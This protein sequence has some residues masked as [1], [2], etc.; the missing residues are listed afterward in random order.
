MFSA[1]GKILVRNFTLINNLGTDKESRKDIWQL[2]EGMSIYENIFMSNMCG[3]AKVQDSYN[4]YSTLPIT[5]NTYLQIQLQDTLT[6]K[7]VGGVYKIY[8]VSNIEQKSPKLQTYIL[9]FASLPMFSSKNVRISQHVTGKVPEVIRD[10][11]QKISSKGIDITEDNST[12]N[13]F[14]PFMSA[15]SAINLL[16]ENAK[17]KA[18]IPDYCYWETFD[19]YNCKSL[20]DCLMRNPVHDFSTNNKLNYDPTT[21]FSYSDYIS[22]DELKVKYTFD[23][24]NTLYNGFDGST[25]Y[26]YDPIKGQATFDQVGDSTLARIIT[27][28]D[29]A[30]DYKSLSRRIQLLRNITNTYYY[31]S[32]PGLLSRSSGDIANVTIYNGNNLNIK[33]TTLSGK[34]LICGIVHVISNDEYTQHIT[35]GDYYLG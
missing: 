3:I 32:V 28:S 26:S 23:S 20:S 25:I 5:S 8:K 22:I 14:L 16:V 30:L 31:I 34:R 17:W 10:I 24:L 4:L 6:G 11:H 15:D 7:R 18:S 27:F 35:L 12:T 19:N 21:A 1:P 13:I 9:H 29:S 2:V 33:D